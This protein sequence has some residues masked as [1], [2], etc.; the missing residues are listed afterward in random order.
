MQWSSRRDF[1]TADKYAFT[2]VEPSWG[3]GIMTSRTLAG[4]C[5][6]SRTPE[7]SGARREDIM[8]NGEGT[9]PPCDREKI[10]TVQAEKKSPVECR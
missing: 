5:S 9:G 7:I 4:G 10:D 2:G 1:R 8:R 3:S 6:L